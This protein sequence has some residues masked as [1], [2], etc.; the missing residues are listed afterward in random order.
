MNR[1]ETLQNQHG[2]WY[3]EEVSIK[4]MVRDFF[5]DLYTDEFNSYTP[6]IVPADSFPRLST[7]DMDSLAR[8][9]TGSDIRKAIFEMDAFKAPGPDGYPALFFQKQWDLTGS[10]VTQTALNI[11]HGKEFP[12]GLNET[13]LVLIPKVE[14]PQSVTQ[15]RPIGLCNVVYKAITKSIVNRLKPVLTKLIAPTQ[16][17]FVPRR[18]ITDNIIIVQEMLHSMRRKKGSKGFMAIKIDLE[19]A[20]DRLRWQFIRETLLEARIPQMMIYVILNCISLTTFRILWHGE[21]TEAFTPSRGVRQGDPLSP[22]LFVLCMERLN[23]LIEAA[24]EKGDWKPIVASRGGP[25]VASLFFADDLILFGEASLAQAKIIKDCL[26]TFCKASGQKVSYNKSSV[27]FSNNVEDNLARILSEELEIPRTSDLGRY[28]GMPTLHN[29]V[30]KQTFTRLTERVNKRLSGLE[31]QTPIFCRE[32][33]AY[34]IHVILNPILCD[35]NGQITK[36]FM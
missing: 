12:E 18:Q 7:E 19:K 29:R 20:Y 27:F 23:H 9:F 1:I 14:N 5:K 11:L 21:K 6:Y 13:F 24:V 35:A 36:I 4:N 34:S 33:D 17:S 22:Y 3:S 16:S 2:E 8:P 30:T 28:L 25:S 10:Q 31:S 26:A 15:L 32:I